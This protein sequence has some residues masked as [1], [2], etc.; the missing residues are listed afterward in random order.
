MLKAG[1]G[2]HELCRKHGILDAAS[3][4]W[5]TKHAGLEVSEVKKM[6][7]MEDENGRMKQMVREQAMDI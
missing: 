1:L 4:K 3:Y 7:Q 6:R 2:G 5:R